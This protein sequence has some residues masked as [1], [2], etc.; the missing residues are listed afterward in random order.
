MQK[1]ITRMSQIGLMLL[2]IGLIAVPAIAGSHKNRIKGPI[3]EP[4]DVTRQCLKCHKGAAKDFM[5][6]VH[7]QWAQ[8]QEVDGKKVFIG[9]KNLINNYCTAV[10]GGNE[11]FCAKCHAGYG[12]TDVDTFDFDNPENIDCLV[13]HDTTG[14]YGKMGNG[15]GMPSKVVP[16]LDVAQNVGKPGRDQC[17]SCHFFG[18]GGDAVK[19]GDLDS[20]M[21]YPTKEIDVH[22]DVEG[23]D[24]A[25]IECHT[26]EDHQISGH[27]LYVGPSGKNHTTC[28]QCHGEE[29]HSESIL[30]AHIDTVACQT[31]HI[32][33]VAKD[34]ATKTSWDWSQA[35]DPNRGPEKE[36]GHTTYVK[37]KGKMEYVKKLVPEYFWSN[38]QGKPYLPGQKIDPN[39][40]VKIA[41][42]LG[43]R[44]DMTAKIAPFKI[45]RGKQIYDTEYNYLLT[46]K[47]AN[48][49]G[50][51]NDFDW[52]KAARLGSEAGGVK[53]S[54]KYDF[55]AT[56]MYWRQ[57][58][59]VSP[60][61]QALSCLDCHGDNGR[62]DWA[63]LGYSADPMK[64]KSA[65]RTK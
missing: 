13:C 3:N 9:K 50:Y 21:S 10:N 65:A 15:A 57:N 4:Q 58:H 38:G 22:M 5:K 17:G 1:M 29:V 52:D 64:D 6:T 37:K 34:I 63:A 40:V 59:M 24:F 42:P 41:Y 54:G 45:M 43:D 56:E 30:N 61:E 28:T 35:G 26:T 53:Y 31:C 33:V 2:L 49:G 51:W 20:S 25:C 16:L 18:G 47:V 27:S 11:Q 44:N 48:E 39:K 55:V 19:H 14:R 12:M 62:L 36:H 32:P 23:N 46:A 7:W 60:A 8:E